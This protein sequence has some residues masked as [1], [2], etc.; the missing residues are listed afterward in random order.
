MNEGKGK[1]GGMVFFSLTSSQDRR[2]EGKK[3]KPYFPF[4][5]KNR[6]G[7]GEERRKEAGHQLAQEG[8][9]RKKASRS[10]IFAGTGKKRER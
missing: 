8:G 6:R 3:E 4:L 10:A 1:R 9:K 7:A 5:R 2:R